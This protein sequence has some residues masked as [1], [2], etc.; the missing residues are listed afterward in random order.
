MKYVATSSYYVLQ[1]IHSTWTTI[2]TAKKWRKDDDH[3]S[4][5]WSKTG[6]K[7]LSHLPSACHENMRHNIKSLPYYILYYHY[8]LYEEIVVGVRARGSR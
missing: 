7:N 8:V 5:R 3:E 6:N 1:A 4:V 2:H